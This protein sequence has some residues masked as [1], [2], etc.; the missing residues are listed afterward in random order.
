[1]IV[2]AASRGKGR[3][4]GRERQAQRL[5]GAGLADTACDRDDSGTAALTRSRAESRQA[6]ECVGN[7]QERHRR[8]AG[9]LA[10][11]HRGNGALLESGT[12]E[13]MAVVVGSPQRNEQ[14]TSSETA[15]IDRYARSGP[16]RDA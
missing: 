10:V 8:Q 12:D 3:A 4:A 16:I 9:Y 7:V 2:E 11:H 1:M 15:R 6:G 14:V 5:L 13:I